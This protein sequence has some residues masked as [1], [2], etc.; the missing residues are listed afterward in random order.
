[1]IHEHTG[2][3]ESRDALRLTLLKGAAG[4]VGHVHLALT[5]TGPQGWQS[6]LSGPWGVTEDYEGL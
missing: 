2:V 1:M 3:K 6:H 5:F 4:P